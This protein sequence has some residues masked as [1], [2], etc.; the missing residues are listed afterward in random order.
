MRYLIDTAALANNAL[1]P[2][3]LPERIRKLLDTDE[4]KGL[5][6]VSLLEL[7]IHHRRGRLQL[8]GKLSDFFETALAQDI[9]ILDL[10]PAVAIATNELPADFS[11]DPFDRTIAAT[12]RVFSLTLITADAAIRDSR[13]CKVEFYPFRPARA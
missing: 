5:C 10:T 1:T 6:G 8:K 4:V 13:F 7:A 9:E 12:A 11:G 2:Q 3:I